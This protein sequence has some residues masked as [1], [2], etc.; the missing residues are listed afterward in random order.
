M[1]HLMNIT[2]KE[3]RELLTPSSVAS[4]LV[5]VVLFAA[6][7]SMMSGQTESAM[8][9]QKLL[10][11]N[12]DSDDWAVSQIES[13][14]GATYPDADLSEYI[15]VVDGPLAGQDL[16][17][18]MVE[19][20]AGSAIVIGAGFHSNVTSHK[21]GEMYATYI[22]SS[23]GLFGNLS[24][25]IAGSIIS[26]LNLALMTDQGWTEP[27]IDTGASATNIN[28]DFA[29]GVTPTEIDSAV[30]SQ[31]MMV[32]LIIMIVIVMI[33]SIVISS[34]GNE[35][36]NKT[37]ETLLTM[38]VKRTTIVTGKLLAAGITGLVFGAAYMVGM[39]MYTNGIMSGTVSGVNL[40]DIGLT[41]DAFD[42]V[43]ILI[44]M[45]LAILAALGICMIMG[46]FAKNYKSAQTLTLP[47]SVLAMIPM[48]VIMF[49]GWNGLPLVL[50]AVL[51]IIPFT[52]PMMVMTNLMF[53]DMTLVYAGIAYLAVFTVA[54][55]LVTVRLY[56]S[57]IL[58]TGISQNPYVVRMKAAFSG[59]KHTE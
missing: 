26:S 42:W 10:V 54:V 50:Q 13:V 25:A 32:P 57:D 24:S 1:N 5:V 43:L 2:K 30:S 7:G 59:K 27:A 9:P 31:N 15:T 56:K 12:N 11:V 39:M 34:M 44:Q 38:P 20:G 35:K 46:A 47:I 52:H 45:F 6:L 53:G 4:V 37:L 33:G 18:R 21:T 36:E 19:V 51:F 28:G 16:V 22:Y 58:I 49:M 41:I 48:F 55:I 8:A 29:S 14:Y 17:D 40:A 23:G 3:L